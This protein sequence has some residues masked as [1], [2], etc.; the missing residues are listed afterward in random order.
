VIAHGRYFV[1]QMAEVAVPRELFRGSRVVGKE[2]SHLPAG[3]H[4]TI[5]KSSPQRDPFNLPRRPYTVTPAH[6]TGGSTKS[7]LMQHLHEVATDHNN[8]LFAGSNNHI[9]EIGGHPP[10]TVEESVKKNREALSDCYA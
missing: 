10:R 6:Q 5:L 7:V 8:G 2:G 4:R 9:A 3:S 1:F